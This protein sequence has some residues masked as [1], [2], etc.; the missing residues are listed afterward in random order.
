MQ[1]LT[2]TIDCGLLISNGKLASSTGLCVTVESMLLKKSGIEKQTKILPKDFFEMTTP[3]VIGND[4]VLKV[5]GILKY[6]GDETVTL[7]RDEWIIIF[8]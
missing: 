8:I 6:I 2:K 4:G 1:K 7:S 5:K 3:T